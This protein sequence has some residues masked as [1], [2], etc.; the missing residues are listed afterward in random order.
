[1]SALDWLSYLAVVGL[2]MWLGCTS[3]QA[4]SANEVLPASKFYLSVVDR[5]GAVS[6]SEIPHL[7]D[8][9][10]RLGAVYALL[11]IAH[12]LP[13]PLRFCPPVEFEAEQGTECTCRRSSGT[14]DS[15]FT[16]SQTKA[17]NPHGHKTQIAQKRPRA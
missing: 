14:T 9:G 4:A 15:A 3:A 8:A 1:M 17:A 12:I 10:E 5:H 2:A 11:T 6:Q 16:P 13:D 7:M